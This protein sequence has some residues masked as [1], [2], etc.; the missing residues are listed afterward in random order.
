MTSAHTR[1]VTARKK[2]PPTAELLRLGPFD[3]P[4]VGARHV[5]VALPSPASKRPELHPLLF[6]WDGQ[7]VFDDGPSFAGG[8]HLHTAAARRARRGKVAPVVVALEHGNGERIREL[9]PYAGSHGEPLLDPL[10]DWVTRTLVPAM[11]RQFNLVPGPHTTMVGGSSMGGL[12]SLYAHLRHPDV[13]GGVMAMSPS[14]F[15]G[16][17]GIFTTLAATSKPW[18]SRVYLDAGGMEAGGRLATM[19]ARLHG[20][21]QHQGWHAHELHHRVVKSG[22]H[23]ETAWR[24]RVPRALRYLYG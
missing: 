10:L 20:Q 16:G 2:P 4:H 18:F 24:R 7:N 17:G 9:S 21:F 23:T 12:A 11:T 3:I 14:I 15:L 8:W 1:A 6:M 22:Q 19:A 5:R 13:F